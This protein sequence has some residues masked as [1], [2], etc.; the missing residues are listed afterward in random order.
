MGLWTLMSTGSIQDQLKQRLIW[1]KM[2]CEGSYERFFDDTSEIRN[3]CGSD[4]RKDAETEY[5]YVDG[6]HQ[7]KVEEST[8]DTSDGKYMEFIRKQL[9]LLKTLDAPSFPDTILDK[10]CWNFKDFS[11][12]WCGNLDSFKHISGLNRNSHLNMFSICFNWHIWE[13]L[14]SGHV[15]SWIDVS[16]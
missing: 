9:V 14:L 12:C 15:L 1:N 13:I 5:G 2:L 7:R 6:L 8:L 10:E 16:N 11:F 3:W 4:V